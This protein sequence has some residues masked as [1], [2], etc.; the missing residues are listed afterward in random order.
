M[1]KKK[2][3]NDLEQ[4]L[5]G[6]IA[7]DSVY[8]A[9]FETTENLTLIFDEKTTMLKVNSKFAELMGYTKE[10]V[11]GKISWM[12]FVLKEDLDMM[13]KYNTIRSQSPQSAPKNYEFRVKNK[14][15]EILLMYITI[16]IIP[17]T[18]CR[19]ASLMDITERREL[20]KEMIY[21]NE[22]VQRRIGFDL[23][24]DL[25]PH[26]LGIE[27]LLNVVTKKLIKERSGITG[28]V[29]KIRKF[30]VEAVQKTRGYAKVLC[31]VHLAEYGL[32]SAIQDLVRNT[33]SMFDVR[34]IFTLHGESPDGNSDLSKNI[35]FIIKEAVHNAVKHARAENVSIS[36]DYQPPHLSV[37]I[38]DDGDGFNVLK[39]S[40]GIGLK[41]MKYRAEMLGAFF[42]IVSNKNKGT[43]VNIEIPGLKTDINRENLL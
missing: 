22:E 26:L 9:L 4:F 30:V 40:P 42:E 3:N 37:K 24:D 27:A 32:E 11:E 43:I 23:H 12:D 35:Y 29:E 21:I 2:P 33:E 38:E 1:K 36:I 13:I 31:P 20:E 34:C 8:L 18:T 19:I 6:G 41:I 16:G 15:G 14:N 39:T 10:E 25:A 17:G 5:N 7:S 28:E